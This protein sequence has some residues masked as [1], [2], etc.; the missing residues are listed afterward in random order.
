MGVKRLIPFIQRFAPKSITV[1]PLDSFRTQS[2]AVDSNIFLHRFLR[3]A[4]TR[5]S[6]GSASGSPGLSTDVIRHRHIYGFFRLTR[7]LQSH[8][9]TPV[10]IFDGPKRPEAKKLEIER[11]QQSQA[12]LRTKVATEQRR[13]VRIQI[14]QSLT[15]YFRSLAPAKQWELL[16][17]YKKLQETIDPKI[18][19]SPDKNFQAPPQ[20]NL[21]RIAK[22]LLRLRW[23]MQEASR[24]LTRKEKRANSLRLVWSKSEQNILEALVSGD[25]LKEPEAKPPTPEVVVEA[26]KVKPRV[27]AKSPKKRIQEQQARLQKLTQVHSAHVTNVTIQSTRVNSAVI[28]QTIVLLRKMGFRCYMTEGEE[29]EAVCAALYHDGLTQGTLSD[30]TDLLLLGDGPLLR[31]MSL[32]SRTVTCVDP[33]VVRQELQ[34]TAEQFVDFCILCGTDFCSTL[35]QVGP[36]KAIE[37]IRRHH[38]IEQILKVE[39]VDPRD[40]FNF[41]EARRLLTQLPAVPHKLRKPFESKKDPAEQEEALKKLLAK[42]DVAYEPIMTLTDITDETPFVFANE[43]PLV[44][45]D[46]AMPT[47]F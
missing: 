26:P 40:N 10:F 12:L 30:D 36:I 46:K 18:L 11:R 1:K 27:K 45:S 21:R 2:L 8:G 25:L 33:V 17:L 23:E 14:L 4:L 39:H 24:E 15:D 7:L 31:S 29:S 42:Y 28:R 5:N 16:G 9:I 3:T 43:A 37:L 19:A 6:P 47:A 35:K 41:Q 13:Q 22:T 20:S 38:S 34:L 44:Q 32:N